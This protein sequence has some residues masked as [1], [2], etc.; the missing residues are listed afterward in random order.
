MNP[1]IV[2]L[3]AV[4]AANSGLLSGVASVLTALDHGISIASD[5]RKWPV[6]KQEKKHVRKVKSSGR[7]LP[8][9]RR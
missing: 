9:T 5:V 3:L 1:A 2:A 8:E 7:I 6:A 4:V